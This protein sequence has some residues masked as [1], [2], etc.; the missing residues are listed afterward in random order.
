VRDLKLKEI[1]CCIINQILYSK[2]PLGV[3]LRFLDP[4]EA[5]RAM[6]YFHDSSCGGHHFWRTTLYKI[7]KAGNLW[8]NPFTGA[9]SKIRDYTKCQKFAGKKKLKS[10]PLKPIAVSGPF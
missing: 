6:L 7:L 3:L 9:F 5:Q 10:L 8:P 4:Q 1:K 2:D